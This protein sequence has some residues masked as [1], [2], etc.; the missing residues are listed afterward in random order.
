MRKAAI[1]LRDA[2]MLEQPPFKSDHCGICGCPRQADH[3]EPPKGR[4]GKHS[5]TYAVDGIANSDKCH[6]H[7][8]GAGGWVELLPGHM[9][10]AD[11]EAAMHVNRRRGL[12][13]R[14]PIVAGEAFELL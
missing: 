4:A 3:H 2:E 5:V 12:S 1:S 7:L 10:V 13:G 11:S 14:E 8:H 6:G 9:A